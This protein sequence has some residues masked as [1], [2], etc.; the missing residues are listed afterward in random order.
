MVVGKGGVGHR[1][2]DA[3]VPLSLDRLALREAAVVVALEPPPGA[4]EWADGLAQIG[5]L[6][7][8]A[9]HGPGSR[10][11]RWRSAGG[12]H[13]RLH[14]RAAPGGSG[15]CRVHRVAGEEH[16]G[17][18]P[19]A[20]L[21]VRPGR[22]PRDH[23]APSTCTAAGPLVALVGNP[24]CG[25]TA[26]FNLLTGSRQKVANYAGV[27]VERK[28]G[29][30]D[31][32]GRPRRCGVLDLPG[33]YSLHPRSPDERVT[34]DVLF[35]RAA[36]RE[37]ARP[38]GVRRRRHQSAAQSAP[39]AGGAPARPALR[40]GAEHDRPGRAPRHARRRRG[41]GA[42]TRRAGGGHRRRAG[43]RRARAARACSTGPTSGSAA[44][45]PPRPTRR[46]CLQPA[47]ARRRPRRGAPHPAAPGPGRPACRT[48]ASDRI[49]RVVLHPVAGPLLLALLLF[50]VFQAVFAG[51]KRRWPGSRPA[52]PCAGRRP[53][54]ALLAPRLAAQPAGR[55]R[56]RR[57][58]RR[59]RVPAADRDPVLL[60][61]G[62][63]GIAATCRARPSCSTA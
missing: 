47:D 43:R 24:N 9:R 45:R 62:A 48:P 36:G 34:A 26:L 63:G 33:A 13:R 21:A 37:A 51:P 50:L 30:L 7:G 3:A 17:Q 31:H 57:R 8:E 22:S 39:G 55:R 35:G 27:T 11:A 15:L 16:P 6:P 56:D 25:K 40:G 42:R 60:H 58:R 32:A 10:P 49:D 18:T 44:A 46:R 29:R 41:A 59:A 20:P 28:E 5:F 52:P 61:P 38:G 12:A 19:M 2:E 53:S 23:R 4:P 54:P 14:L 1:L